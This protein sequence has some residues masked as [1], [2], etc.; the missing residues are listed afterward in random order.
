M[1]IAA[2]AWFIYAARPG[3]KGPAEL[4]RERY[5]LP[6]LEPDEILVEPVY[7]CWEANLTH[8]L[9]RDPIDVC[10]AR[11]DARAILGNAGTG[12]IV[13]LG[14]EVRG[15]YEGQAVMMGGIEADEWG[16]PVRVMG[17]DS[18]KSGLLTT[19]LKMRKEDVIP[20]PE[21]T[22]YSLRQWAAF[23]NRHITAWANW[24][25]AH[26]TFRLLIG[27]DELERL[28]VWSW[29]GGTGLA[30][31]Q[32][33]TLLGHRGVAIASR[34][35]RLDLIRRSGVE[36]VDRS[37]FRGLAFDEERFKRDAEFA[38]QCRTAE[39]TFLETVRELTGGQGVQIF[40]EPLGVPVFRAT[41]KALGRHG[42]LTTMGWKAGMRIWYLRALETIQRH[43]FVH[44]HF[45]RR[46]EVDDAVAFGEERGWMPIVD[47]RVYSFDEIPQLA[48]DYAAGRYRMFPIY[49]INP[50]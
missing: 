5:E 49:R 37:P 33:A 7:G 11:G 38:Q 17:F 6:D 25:V 12:R 14:G 29:G 28:N 50:E 45:A 40:V 39:R 30:E 48:A 15:L 24:R 42:I 23:N 41:L 8:A 43:Q 44:T 20:I 22:R 9:E 32:L 2:E 13:A 36:A 31:V 16:Y 4:V 27:A 1:S 19:R 46:C 26:G 3:E 34:P 21:G 18:R 10:A 35:E 47:E